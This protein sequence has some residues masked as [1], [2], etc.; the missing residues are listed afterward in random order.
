MINASAD[1]Q[2]SDGFRF[3]LVDVSR[4]VLANYALPLQRKWVLAYQ[5]KDLAA[6]KKYSAEFIELIEDMD[7]LLATRKDFLLGP[8]VAD[9]RSWG[10]TE[11]E[12]ALYEMNAKDLITLWGDKDCP[13]NEY[14][15]KQWSG[16]MTD[17]YKP[18]WEQYFAQL[19]LDI[20]G[21]KVFDKQVFTAQ[22]KAWEW[23][24]V[25]MHKDYSVKPQ[26]DPVAEARQ[27]YQKY[28]LRM[29]QLN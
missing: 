10:K 5:Q 11:S 7:R 17:F 25:N 9:A 26:G 8:W 6:F 15:C 2:Q 19:E 20:A 18:R 22:I 4:Q 3:D 27:L 13:L 12:K 29:L 23:T 21:E 1:L 14:A 24:W 16:L 28:W